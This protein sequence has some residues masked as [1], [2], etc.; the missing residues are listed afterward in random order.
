M[1]KN[2]LRSARKETT[3]FLSDV[4]IEDKY[5]KKI[6]SSINQMKVQLSSLERI[7]TFEE[8]LKN[9]K[10]AI[11]QIVTLLGI[12]LEKFKRVISWIRLSK[13]YTFD[14]EWSPTAMRIHILERK[15]Y[16]E[17]I[18]ELF[19]KGYKS[20][21]FTSIVPKFI[22][23]DFRFDK[24]TLERLKSDDYLRRLVKAKLTNS[25]NNEYCSLYYDLLYQEINNISIEKNVVFKRQANVP[26][27]EIYD[28]TLI[29][30]NNKYIIINSSFYLTTSSTQTK[31][32]DNITAMRS[33]LQ[34]KNNIKMV[35]ILDGAGW[36]G[37]SAD[38]IKVYNDCD[39]FLTL[40]TISELKDIIDEF[41]NK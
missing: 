17:L 7:T 21:R 35:N 24:S 39:Y 20:S 41:L 3:M 14:S 12:S 36:I 22:L 23:D 29:E 4:E 37:R 27:T 8:L 38:Y 15:D 9:N 34:C 6:Q 2:E 13:G 18:Y 40:K 11:E 26:D 25:Y 10:N 28:V 19:T 1:K 32:A 33:S 16:M 31:Y 5:E 30:H